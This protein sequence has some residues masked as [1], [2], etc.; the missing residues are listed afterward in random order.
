[1]YNIITYSANLEKSRKGDV[2]D[3]VVSPVAPAFNQRFRRERL[4]LVLQRFGRT[5]VKEILSRLIIVNG[6][7]VN[8]SQEPVGGQLDTFETRR[9]KCFF[10]VTT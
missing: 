10:P 9:C 8:V 4:K 3:K 6:I 7:I 5:Q 1:M 2:W